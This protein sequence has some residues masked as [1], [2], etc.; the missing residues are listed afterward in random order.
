MDRRVLRDTKY[1]SSITD[2]Y[3]LMFQTRRTY[4]ETKYSS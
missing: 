2:F 1:Y 4:H 3:T